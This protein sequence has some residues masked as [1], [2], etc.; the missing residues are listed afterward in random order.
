MTMRIPCKTPF[1]F[2][3]FLSASNLSV[4]CKTSGFFSIKAFSLEAEES[5]ST[6]RSK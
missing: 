1:I 3:L 6:I 5:I 4:K 2:P